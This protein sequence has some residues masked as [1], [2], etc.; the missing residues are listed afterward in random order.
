VVSRPEGSEGVL[1]KVWSSFD[2]A[3]RKNAAQ[4]ARGVWATHALMAVRVLPAVDQG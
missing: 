1:R 2:G 4:N 3:G